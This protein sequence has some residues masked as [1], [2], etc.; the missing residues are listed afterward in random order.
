MVRGEANEKAGQ[1]PVW[2]PR[3]PAD[4]GWGEGRELD[5]GNYCQSGAAG[6]LHFL[7]QMVR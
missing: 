4:E 3:I 1:L 5:R 7:G 2:L 6:G